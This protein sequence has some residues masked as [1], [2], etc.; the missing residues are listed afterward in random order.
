MIITEIF[1]DKTGY[2]AVLEKKNNYLNIFLFF[3]FVITVTIVLY[4]L[5]YVVLSGIISADTAVKY[6]FFDYESPNI[7]S[8]FLSNY[9]HEPQN[10]MHLRENALSFVIISSFIGI[11]Y[12]CFFPK[13]QIRMPDYFLVSSYLLIFFVV[14]FSVSS[15]SYIFR[16]LGAFNDGIRYS[17]GFSGIVWA[18]LGLLFFLAA[19]FCLR[20]V[21]LR[22]EGRMEDFRSMIPVYFPFLFIVS[23]LVIFPVFFIIVD[24]NTKNNLYA[25]LAGF[26]YGWFIPPLLG[27]FLLSSGRRAKFSNC[28]LIVVSFLLPFVITGVLLLS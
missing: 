19:V 5:Q 7:F 8:L 1:A 6:F 23:F 4:L 3:A 16:E 10:S 20:V 2:F 26:T 17:V 24:V 18:L 22:C 12:F 13:Y 9:M 25:H 27:S 14:P 11:T 21:F 15:V 28:M